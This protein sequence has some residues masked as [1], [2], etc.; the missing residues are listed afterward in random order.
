MAKNF[1]QD[2]D[3]LTLVAPVG[4]VVSGVPVAIGQ[5]VVVPITSAAEG[6]KFG[7]KT[8]GVWNVAVADGL[9]AGAA[10]GILDG[11]IV[12]AATASSIACG[13]LVTAEVDGYAD[14]MLIN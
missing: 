2:G 7:G 6:E 12:A 3:V 8:N 5:L 1:V 4:G 13:K 10:V 9:A 14:W 11:D